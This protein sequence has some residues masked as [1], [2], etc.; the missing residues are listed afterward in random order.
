MLKEYACINCGLLVKKANCI[1]KYCSNKCQ[2]ELQYKNAINSWKTEGTPLGKSP[3]RRYLIETYGYKCSVCNIS[4]WNN[5]PIVL[6]M[7]HKDGDSYNNSEDNLCLICP[8]CHSQTNTYKGK[9]VGKGRH[10]R[11]ERYKQGK[12]Y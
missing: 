11:R 3:L 9:N 8:N 7:E 4:E 2:Q 5:K 6:E 12:S 10:Y 1:G